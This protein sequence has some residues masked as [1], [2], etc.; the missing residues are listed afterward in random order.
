[1]GNVCNGGILVA[2]ARSV[3]RGKGFGGRVLGDGRV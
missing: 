3:E 1:M 2:W